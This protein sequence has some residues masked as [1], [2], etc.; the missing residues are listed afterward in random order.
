MPEVA[1]QDLIADVL[2]CGLVPLSDFAAL[3]TQGDDRAGIAFDNGRTMILPLKSLAGELKSTGDG[4]DNQTTAIVLYDFDTRYKS[5][6]PLRKGE[7]IGITG[8]I[9]ENWFEGTNKDGRTGIFPASYVQL[10]ERISGRTT[11]ASA[12]DSGSKEPK[13][14]SVCESL[15]KLMVNGVAYKRSD[16][17]GIVS[18]KAVFSSIAKP[19]TSSPLPKSQTN[20]AT[21]TV[22]KTSAESIPDNATTY[23]AIYDYE[24]RSADEL[25]V[26]AGDIIFVS[27]FC[28]DGWFLGTSL[29]TGQRGTFPGN[30]A[31][32][33]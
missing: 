32:R 20:L 27:E 30:Y 29:R 2:Q 12:L 19:L 23:K 6:L 1:K 7:T 33:F 5:E 22:F 25:E 14:S 10:Q 4:S 16:P 28:D 24:P 9:D 15:S 17:F 11:F 3:G 13:S 21:T 26:K 18:E 8:K 31:E